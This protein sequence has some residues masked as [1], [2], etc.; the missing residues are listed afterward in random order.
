MFLVCSENENLLTEETV[1]MMVEDTIEQAIKSYVEAYGT[2]RRNIMQV[3]ELVNR[4]LYRVDADVRMNR[5]EE[6][7]PAA[8][9]G[10]EWAQREV[11]RWDWPGPQEPQTGQLAEIAAIE[12]RARERMDQL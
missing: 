10:L 4:E 2:P 12:A 8:E 3:F 9:H 6:I 5:L 11:L 7:P 1:N